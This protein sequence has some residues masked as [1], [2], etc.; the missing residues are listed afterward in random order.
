[1][2]QSKWSI[3]KIYRNKKNLGNIPLLREAT[4]DRYPPRMW[5]AKIN[6]VIIQRITYWIRFTICFFKVNFGSNA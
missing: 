1:M 6:P 4:M 5:G 3:I 2:S